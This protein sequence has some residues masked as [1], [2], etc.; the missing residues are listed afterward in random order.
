M[1]KLLCWLGIHSYIY[2]DFVNKYGT[3]HVPL[4]R[5]CEHCG[6]AFK[7]NSNEESIW[8]RIK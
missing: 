6:K 1:N 3:V 2:E 4:I 8:W 5:K 7:R